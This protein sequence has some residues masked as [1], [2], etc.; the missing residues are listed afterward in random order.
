MEQVKVSDRI[1][2]ESKSWEWSDIEVGHLP[3]KQLT[4]FQSLLFHI[5]LHAPPGETSELCWVR[6]KKQ[7]LMSHKGS[8]TPVTPHFHIYV[9]PPAPPCPILPLSHLLQAGTIFTMGR[10][11][12]SEGCLLPLEGQR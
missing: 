7:V 12:S 8:E 3:C 10:G 9:T 2:V 5:V 4:W 11:G 1:M 6:P